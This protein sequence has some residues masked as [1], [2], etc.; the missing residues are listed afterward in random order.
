MGE[1]MADTIYDFTCN[2]IDGRELSLGSYRG[3]VLLIVNTASKCSFTPQYLGLEKLYKD[4]R[5][6]GLEVLGFPCNQFGHQEP[7]SQSQIMDFC[8]T[9]Y[10]VSFPMFAKIN[11][12]GP[13][14]DPLYDFLKTDAPGFLGTKMIKWNFTKFLVGRDGRVV[15]RFGPATSPATIEA[16]IECELKKSAF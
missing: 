5:E 15:D 12:N 16:S 1:I 6:K 9:N 10:G 3:L 2:S 14:A 4:Y 13:G 8:I 7:G 11:V